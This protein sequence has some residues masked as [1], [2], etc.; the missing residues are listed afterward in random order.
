[1]S[2][3]SPYLQAY[4]KSATWKHKT[5]NDGNDDTFTSTAIT[6][7]WAYGAKVIRTPQGEEL[8]CQAICKCEEAVE[9]DDVLTVDGRD[10]PV[11][12]LVGAS[13]DGSMRSLAMGGSRTV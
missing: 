6:V 13:Y 7:L 10:W 2:L 4:G 3:I 9:A 5:G 11:L 12:G 8:A 1:M